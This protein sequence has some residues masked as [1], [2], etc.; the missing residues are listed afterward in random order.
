[1]KK[2]IIFFIFAFLFVFTL[3]LPSFM[4]NAKTYDEFAQE[5]TYTDDAVA[6]KMFNINS[7]IDGFTLTSEK[8]EDNTDYLRYEMSKGGT[9]NFRNTT[10]VNN[11]LWKKANTNASLKIRFRTNALNASKQIKMYLPAATGLNAYSAVLLNLNKNQVAYNT[12]LNSKT[13]TALTN[14]VEVNVWHE[15][16]VIIEIAANRADNQDY[17]HAYLDGYHLYSEQM[18]KPNEESNNWNGNLYDINIQGSAYAGE[19]FDIDYIRINDTNRI[20]FAQDFEYDSAISGTTS[21]ISKY[22]I[23]SNSGA[24]PVTSGQDDDGTSYARTNLIAANKDLNIR[25]TT[26]AKGLFNKADTNAYINVR[27]RVNDLTTQKYIRMYLPKGTS[28]VNTETGQAATNNITA[29]LLNIKT[30][31]LQYNPGTGTQTVQNSANLIKVN[32]WHS[33]EVIIEAAAN[34]ADGQD[35]IHAYLDGNYLYSA[36]MDYK[37]NTVVEDI[38]WNGNLYDLNIRSA[39]ATTTEYLDLDYIE[40]KEYNKV[41]YAEAN[42]VTLIETE[43]FNIHNQVKNINLD[44]TLPIYNVSLQS[45]SVLSYDKAT[46]VITAPTVDKDVVEKVTLTFPLGYSIDVNVKIQNK[47]TLLEEQISED[48]NAIRFVGTISGIKE[49]ELKYA[50]AKFYLE[51]TGYDGNVTKNIYT[52]Y[53]SVKDA[54]VEIDNTWYLVYTVN[55]LLANNEAL[56]GRTIT[57]YFEF[58]LG[59]MVLTSNVKEYTI[60]NNA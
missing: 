35:Y 3:S 46:G 2:R 50:S 28:V 49:E 18:D 21:A 41:F 15:L 27:F 12:G 11:G 24:M 36:Q 8:D 57:V 52:V 33:F 60:V 37:N 45:N 54:K 10:N 6:T 32:T 14:K 1:M 19:T 48:L 25:N 53:T 29:N 13:L 22:N 5:F 26:Q 17:L 40:V 47:S 56:V 9:I 31:N 30:G 59:D 51:I 42:D 55:G 38:T 4:V 44:A 20:D 7:S 43:N 58:T 16:H 34:S 39:A 23:M